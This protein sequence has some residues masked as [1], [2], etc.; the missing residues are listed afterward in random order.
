M[1]YFTVHNGT[2]TLSAMCDR[3]M[4]RFHENITQLPIGYYYPSKYLGL[5]IEHNLEKFRRLIHD[6]GIRDGLIAFQAF[7]R[8]NEVMPFDPTYRLDGTVA[9]HMIEKING[10]NVLQ[11]LIHKS[12]AGTMGDDAEIC[13]LENPYFSSPAYEVPILLGKGTITR[14]E[15]F[16]E[17]RSMPD[18]VHICMRHEVG[19]VMEHTADFSQTLCRICLC[20]KDDRAILDDINKIFACVKVLDE[21][22]RDMII[23]RSTFTLS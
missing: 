8:G 11:M 6:L 18:V 10:V 9:Y 5:F 12:L 4:H 23:N 7:V 3:Y 20:A 14:I 19:E 17:V 13:R 21:R 2:A 16:D 15:G 1:V 22:G